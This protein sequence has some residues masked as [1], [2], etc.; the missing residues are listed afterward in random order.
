MIPTINQALE[1]WHTYGLPEQ[2]QKHS[3]LVARVAKWIA[4]QITKN[5]HLHIN[6]E[7]LYVAGLLHDIDKNIPRRSG[8]THPDGGVRLLT[9]LGYGEVADMVRTHPLHAILD[10]RRAPK[11]LD[12]KILYLADKMTKYEVISVDE[13]FRLWE[14]EHITLEEREILHAAYPKAKQ[15]EMEISALMGMKTEEMIKTC[16]NAI[17]QQE[18][19][20]I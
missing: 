16:K 4:E 2:K 17:L 15:I 11:S 1:M 10:P 7:L 18:G 6:Q 19:N 8:E 13:R 3:L 14:A 12:E 9:E 20:S 5:T